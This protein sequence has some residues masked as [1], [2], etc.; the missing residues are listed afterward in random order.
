MFVVQ[1]RA[2]FLGVPFQNFADLQ[3]SFSEIFRHYGYL[4]RNFYGTMGP[5]LKKIWQLY[6]NYRKWSIISTDFAK[7]FMRFL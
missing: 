3:V 2:I 1:G 5:F 7:I 4:F 6:R